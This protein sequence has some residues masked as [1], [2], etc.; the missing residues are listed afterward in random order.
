[1]KLSDSVE[2]QGE[3]KAPPDPN[4]DITLHTLPLK[5]LYGA[6]KLT[7]SLTKEMWK[8]HTHHLFNSEKVGIR[9]LK[10][11]GAWTWA[12]GVEALSLTLSG[13]L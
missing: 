7:Y 6:I 1:M 11:R 9:F 13:L 5:L 2:T 3:T 8:R 12:L 4:T 10:I